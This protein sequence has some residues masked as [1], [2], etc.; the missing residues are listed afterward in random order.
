MTCEF[1]HRLLEDEAR[2]AGETMAD[3][4]AWR[5]TGA[6]GWWSAFGKKRGKNGRKPSPAVHDDLCTVAAENGRARLEFTA[7]GPNQLWLTE[8][9]TAAG[10][11]YLCAIKD[12]FANKIV[13]Y[14]IGSRMHFG[15]A[16]RVLENAVRMRGDAVGCVVHSERGSQAVFNRSS[17]HGRIGV[18]DERV[19]KAEAGPGVSGA[20]R[21]SG[22]AERRVAAGLGAVLGWRSRQGR[23]RVMRAWLR[24]F[25]NRSRTGGSAMLVE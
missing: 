13:G 24:V 18:S 19:G 16:V 7:D 4:A 1:G 12:V 15:L 20:D 3:R 10:K 6:H 9:W 22:A 14:S 8:H 21:V 2:E 5:I 17:Q 25:R 23:R 11:L